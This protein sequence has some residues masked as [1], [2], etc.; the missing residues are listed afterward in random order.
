MSRNSWNSKN[1]IIYFKTDVCDFFDFLILTMTFLF[2]TF[3]LFYDFFDFSSWFF[4][5]FFKWF[6]SRFLTSEIKKDHFLIYECGS[7]CT[8]NF[9]FSMCQAMSC[10]FV[11]ILNLILELQLKCHISAKSFSRFLL[12]LLIMKQKI[13]IYD[14][15]IIYTIQ[16]KSIYR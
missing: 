11:C 9:T 5:F 15:N 7:C 4:D 10:N 2:M 1:W 16:I 3:W 13:Q 8:F 14:N 12:L 6:T